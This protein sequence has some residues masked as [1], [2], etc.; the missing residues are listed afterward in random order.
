MQLRIWQVY[1]PAAFKIA[2][3]LRW[4]REYRALKE[5]TIPGT[6]A[7]SGNFNRKIALEEK[8]DAIREE[9]SGSSE[10]CFEIIRRIIQIRRDIDVQ[11]NWLYVFGAILNH[12]DEIFSRLTL[13]WI[14]SVLDTFSDMPCP[15]RYK[16]AAATIRSFV[17]GIRLGYSMAVQSV[18]DPVVADEPIHFLPNQEIW[19]GIIHF[20]YKTGDTYRNYIQRTTRELAPTPCMASAWRA[21][22]VRMSKY[23]PLNYA[24]TSNKK[25]RAIF[26]DITRG[27]Q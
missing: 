24:L 1:A 25:S 5:Q 22:L 11:T 13:R 12:P 14:I 4:G 18:S 2:A 8:Y 21:A 20:N 15:R 27:P 17:L 10:L 7:Y 6:Y 3:G 16:L 26:E 23:P 9:F 19:D